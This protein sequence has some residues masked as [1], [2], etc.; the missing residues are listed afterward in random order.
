MWPIAWLKRRELENEPWPQSWAMQ[1]SP[2]PPTPA[3]SAAGIHRLQ[4]GDKAMSAMPSA[5]TA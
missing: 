3:T 1:C 5:Q 2:Q 4:C